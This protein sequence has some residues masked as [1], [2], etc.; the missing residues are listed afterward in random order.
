[1]VDPTLAQARAR[2]VTENPIGSAWVPTK[3]AEYDA[4]ADD[5]QYLM[6]DRMRME[7][8]DADRTAATKQYRAARTIVDRNLPILQGTPTAVQVR[9]ATKDSYVMWDKLLEALKATGTLL[10]DV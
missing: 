2:W 6:L 1:M 7:Q 8:R 4:M 9:D 3:Q 10:D 5:R